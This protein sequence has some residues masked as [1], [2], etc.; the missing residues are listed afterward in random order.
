M[1]P[2]DIVWE[3][4]NNN[5]CCAALTRLT[6]KIKEEFALRVHMSKG[7]AYKGQVSE[8]VPSHWS[9]KRQ[10]WLGKT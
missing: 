1:G 3:H 4:Q 8:T 6:D 5:D 7:A 2:D 10:Q 9:R